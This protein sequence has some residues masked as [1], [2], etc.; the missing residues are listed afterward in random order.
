M[1]HAVAEADQAGEAGA[2]GDG[3]GAAGADRPA[4]AARLALRRKKHRRQVAEWAILVVAALI[5]ALLVRTFL[6]QAFYIPSAS[7]EPTL[8]TNDRVLVNKLSYRLHDVHRGDIVV[9]EKPPQETSDI[10]D[11]VKRVIGLPG[12]TVEGRDGRVLVNGDA[13]DEPYLPDDA[14]TAD[15]GPVEI[16]DDSVWVMGD[17]RTNSEDSRFFGPIPTS[18][19][20]GRAFV[21]IWPLTRLGTL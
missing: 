13:L 15:F 7:M 6:F 10:D 18:T 12:E 5:A 16:P 8:K 9:F 3:D 2:P 17:N 19:I 4:R 20:V 11:L 1:M 21:R 14:T